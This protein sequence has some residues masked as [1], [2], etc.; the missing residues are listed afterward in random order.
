MKAKDQP[1]NCYYS[2]CARNPQQTRCIWPYFSGVYRRSFGSGLSLRAL[3]DEVFNAGLKDRRSFGSGL[4]LRVMSVPLGVAQAG[5]PP[6]FRE[7]PFI[8]G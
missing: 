8:E 1:Q 4:S 5:K 3:I 6:L 2:Y 7:R